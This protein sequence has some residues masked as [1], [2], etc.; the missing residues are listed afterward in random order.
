MCQE[1]NDRQH[2]TKLSEFRTTFCSVHNNPMTP[3]TWWRYRAISHLSR[4]SSTDKSAAVP[5]TMRPR[6]TS[7]W[8][9]C[10][11]RA[12]HSALYSLR[13]SCRSGRGRCSCIAVAVI[14]RGNQHAAASRV[15]FRQRAR[16]ARAVRDREIERSGRSRTWPPWKMQSAAITVG[17]FNKLDCVGTSWLS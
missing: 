8:W 7:P 11:S 5:A 17:K 10:E 1:R 15:R 14:P 9:K 3:M 13:G 12:R 6:G 4:G 2:S 16:N